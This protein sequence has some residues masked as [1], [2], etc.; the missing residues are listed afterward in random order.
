MHSYFAGRQ[1]RNTA[2]VGGNIATA[3]PISD[4]NPVWVACDASVIASSAERGEFTL[5]LSSFFTGYRK[6]T[7]PGDAVIVRIVVPLHK[8]E[9]E[10][11][12]VR[13]YK[14]AKRK[15]DDISIVC[16][17][18]AVKVG[19][20]GVMKTVNMAY[21]GMAAWTIQA[22]KT[23]EFLEGQSDRAA[24]FARFNTFTDL[25]PF[26]LQVKHSTRKRWKEL[27]MYWRASSTSLS[28]FPAVRC[29]L[30]YYCHLITLR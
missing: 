2:S 16:A 30:L 14:Q 23:Q 11:E 20:D 27:S 26:F 1:I 8:E 5:P 13:A 28:T 21:G 24:H 22:T 6:T 9:G 19:E 12:V 29:Y 18:M 15:D 25:D 3:S 7:L 10:R 17:C 4:L